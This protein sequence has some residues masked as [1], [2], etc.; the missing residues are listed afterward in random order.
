M[1]TLE[2]VSRMS[3]GVVSLV[4]NFEFTTVCSWLGKAPVCLVHILHAASTR[5]GRCSF[6]FLGLL[7][8]H[9]LRGQ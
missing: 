1:R 7:G 6:L 5:H 3:P 9:S 8:D 2:T 4:T